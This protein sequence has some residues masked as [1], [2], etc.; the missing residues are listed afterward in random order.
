MCMMV[1]VILGDAV[2]FVPGAAAQ[3]SGRDAWLQVS[4]ACLFGLFNLY[5]FTFLGQRFPGKS[6]IEYLPEVMKLAGKILAGI[7]ILYFIYLDVG[8]VREFSELITTIILPR[9]PMVSVVIIIL[10]LSSYAVY[11][12]LEV[13]ARVAVI[14]FPFFMLSVIITALLSLSYWDPG[15]IMPLLESGFFYLFHGLSIPVSWFGDGMVVCMVF[16]RCSNLR[17]AEKRF[18]LAVVIVGLMLVLVTIQSIMMFG[19]NISDFYWS[20]YMAAKQIGL[21][22]EI[23]PLLVWITGLFIKITVYFYAIASGVTQYFGLVSC[24]HVIMPLVVIVAS[25]ALLQVDNIVE[26]LGFYSECVWYYVI[27]QF[28]IPLLLMVFLGLK[29]FFSS[30]TS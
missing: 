14:I 23:L 15:N 24:R 27:F 9:T 28:A 2:V 18:M 1:L 21:G 4:M 13:A 3:V 26:L 5:I 16:H 29:N 19:D 25:L 17:I 12:G 7:Y 11:S 6:F 20:T 10:F 30:S 22:V 8:L